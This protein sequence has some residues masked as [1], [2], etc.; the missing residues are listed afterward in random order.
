MKDNL[1]PT[2][3]WIFDENVSAC[4]DDMISR[5]IPDYANMR[6]QVIG[7]CKPYIDNIISN[8]KPDVDDIYCD[9]EIF[10][11]LDVGCSNGITI[12]NFMNTFGKMGVYRGIEISQ[13]MVEEANNR[14]KRCDANLNIIHADIRSWETVDSFD[15]IT[16][17][18]TLQF[19]PIED[20]LGVVRK[21]Y[22]YLRDGGLCI[23]VEKVIEPTMWLDDLFTKNYYMLK[24][25][26]GYTKEQILA[27]RKALSNVLI[28]LRGEWNINMFKDIGFS[29]V[30]LFWKCLNFEGYILKK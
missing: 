13:N 19:I 10:S 27:K 4:F 22:D 12:E 28:P 2:G 11:L 21:L 25:Y 23:V 14:F 9:E 30:G 5:S 6:K 18:L 15:I 16:S 8:I 20:R 29:E 17:I 1:M 26:N 24:E 7:I 3:S